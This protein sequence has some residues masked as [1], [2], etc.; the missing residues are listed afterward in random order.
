[1]SLTPDDEIR[2]REEPAAFVRTLHQ[3]FP[4]QGEAWQNNTLAGFLGALATWAL[5][6]TVKAPEPKVMDPPGLLR[7][8]LPARPGHPCGA[9]RAAAETAVRFPGPQAAVVRTSP[10][11]GHGRFARTSAR[12]TP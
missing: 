11:S 7:R 4:Q 2:S 9:A 12:R 1:M 8:D 3:D 5:R 6:A 10:I